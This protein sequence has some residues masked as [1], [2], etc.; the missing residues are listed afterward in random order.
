MCSS[1][2]RRQQTKKVSPDQHPT[3]SHFQSNGVEDIESENASVGG[4]SSLS[5]ETAPDDVDVDSHIDIEHIN[6]NALKHLN[7]SEEMKPLVI[8]YCNILP[9]R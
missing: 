6:D 7:V 1:Q 9:M 4:V 3:N 5:Q 2:Q 8:S